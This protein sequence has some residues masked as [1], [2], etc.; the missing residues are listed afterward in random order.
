MLAQHGCELG[1][2]RNLTHG[3]ARLRRDSPGRHPTAPTSELIADMD[4][5]RAEVDVVPVQ[6]RDL[7]EAHSGR[8][9]RR[10][11]CSIARRRRAQQ[12]GQL[13]SAENALVGEPRMRPLIR[14][15]PEQR[16]VS[17]V[18][19]ANRE[20]EH[21]AEWNEQTTDRPGRK[22][23]CAQLGYELGEIVGSDQL[24]LAAVQAWKEVPFERTAVVLERPLPPFARYYSFFEIVEPAPSD[25]AEGQTRRSQQSTF[26]RRDTKELTL[27]ARFLD[28]A[29]ID[30]A[31]ARLAVDHHAHA[32]L[33]IGLYVDPALQARATPLSVVAG[34]PV[35][36][37]SILR[38]IPTLP[39]PAPI[40]VHSLMVSA[41]LRPLSTTNAPGSDVRFRRRVVG[42]QSEV[43]AAGGP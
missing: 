33:P 19:A 43:D 7:G 37:G 16:I 42:R 10:K 15:E 18:T 24:K 11:E 5:P 40:E 13:H 28:R 27:S 9:R 4:D 20:V 1:E 36:Q 22:T 39:S 34:H 17:G 3:G 35:L 31:K 29:R 23:L 2:E 32:V 26:A 12:P 6:R 21:T 14:M 41:R 8:D 25:F 38:C 30:G